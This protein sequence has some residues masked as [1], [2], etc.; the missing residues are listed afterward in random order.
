MKRTTTT[1]GAY[2]R[3]LQAGRSLFLPAL[4]VLTLTLPLSAHA[5][6]ASGL[7]GATGSTV[8]PDGALY[9][10]NMSTSAGGGEVI[11]LVP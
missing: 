7:L 1:T 8:G 6:L 4:A 2:A 3:A 5:Q 10:T 9:V 11:R